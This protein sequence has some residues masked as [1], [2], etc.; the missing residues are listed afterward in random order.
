MN[1]KIYKRNRIGRELVSLS[2]DEER[3]LFSVI[4]FDE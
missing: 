4:E 1:W 3:F 2:V